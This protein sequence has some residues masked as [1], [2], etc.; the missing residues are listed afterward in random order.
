[1]GCPRRIGMNAPN[2][3]FGMRL[4]ESIHQSRPFVPCRCAPKPGGDLLCCKRKKIAM[5]NVCRDCCRSFF[6]RCGKRF[7]VDSGLLCND[8]GEVRDA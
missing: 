3:K 2:P 7:D 1:M 8:M 5:C 4:M 6:E